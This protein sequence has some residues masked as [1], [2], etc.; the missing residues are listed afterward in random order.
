MFHRKVRLSAAMII[1]AVGATAAP[2]WAGDLRQVARVAM[3]IGV[4]APAPGGFLEFCRRT[5]AQCA[6]S[7]ADARDPAAVSRLASQL[8]WQNAFASTASSAPA[9]NGSRAAPVSRTIPSSGRAR[10]ARPYDWS[11]AF[12]ASNPRLPAVAVR[13]APATAPRASS[14]GRSLTAEGHGVARSATDLTSPAVEPDADGI[15]YHASSASEIRYA[16]P[17]PAYA[18]AGGA[19]ARP[20]AAL[21]RSWILPRISAAPGGVESPDVTPDRHG[22]DIAKSS[23]E[24]AAGEAVFVLDRENWALLNRVNRMVNRRIRQASDQS[25]FGQADYWQAPTRDGAYGDCEDYVLAKRKAL[26]DAGVPNAA[27]SIAIVETRWGE[28]HAVLLVT[29]DSGEVVLDSLS[30]WISRWDRVDYTWR[31]RQAPGKV[32]EWV[33]IAT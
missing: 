28:T 2:A 5:P 8:F 20:L 7:P 17:T 14:L 3:P 1:A 26:I 24:P 21:S 29:G 22:D 4:S 18:S 13:H 27:L 33:T 15:R 31:E 11:E 10:P 25:V 6:G 32:F 23:A 19:S 9:S 12:A 16:P 30:S